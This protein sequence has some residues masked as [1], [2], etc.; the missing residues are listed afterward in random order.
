MFTTDAAPSL[1]KLT[2]WFLWH[3][4]CWPCSIAIVCGLQRSRQNCLLC[5]GLLHYLGA[6]IDLSNLGTSNCPHIFGD[7]IHIVPLLWHC[8]LGCYHVGP[9]GLCCES[10]HC[11]HIDI[12]IIQVTGTRP[13]KR[14]S[15]FKRAL[16][17]N[18]THDFYTTL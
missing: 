15:R 11:G 9:A 12:I 16:K 3:T 6:F 10:V 17:N 14:A 8:Q 13:V 4:T 18:M 7:D 5:T 2:S 1:V